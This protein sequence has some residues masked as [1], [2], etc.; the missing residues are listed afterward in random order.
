MQTKQLAI[1]GRSGRSGERRLGA[2]RVTTGC[3][4]CKKRR[5]KCDEAKPSCHRCTSTGRKCDGYA[6]PYV[7]LS[8]PDRSGSVRPTFQ[9]GRP[10]PLSETT[11][12]SPL[13]ASEAENRAFRYFAHGGASTLSGYMDLDLWSR[14]IPQI[15]HAETA[16]RHAVVAIGSL[17]IN[18][19]ARLSASA[20]TSGSVVGTQ[21]SFALQHY[22]K[23]IHSTLTNN[24]IGRPDILIQRITFLLFFCI[25]VLQGHDDAA[26]VLFER[27]RQAEFLSFN[28]YETSSHSASLMTTF[29]RMSL[30]YGMINGTLI[31][32]VGFGSSETWNVVS[33]QIDS[34]TDARAELD[35]LIL[36]SQDLV[37]G[38]LKFPWL[39]AFQAEGDDVAQTW[40]EDSLGDL[41]CSVMAVKNALDSWYTRFTAFTQTQVPFSDR[42]SISACML[43]LHYRMT[44]IWLLAS[45]EVSEM[46][47]DDHLAD[48]EDA[49]SMARSAL[50]LMKRQGSTMSFSFEMCLIPPLYM[51][52][53]SCRYP[54]LRRQA[55]A[56]LRQAPAQEGMWNRDLLARVAERVIEIEEGNGSFSDFDPE[57]GLVVLPP[58]EARVKVAAVSLRTTLDD[59]RHGRVVNFFTMPQGLKESPTI[60]R[61]FFAL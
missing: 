59:G 23:A 47:Y 9:R 24:N 50:D 57:H 20:S 48:F 43:F 32:T 21:L 6:S 58:E 3:I 18:A 33:E 12:N 14:F 49:L 41:F 34:I 13:T 46:V 4:T 15:C 28:H 5:I 30:Q 1:P 8:Q 19:D 2:R 55:L 35:V 53:I 44:K 11:L 29:V 42:D 26:W 39:A 27:A 61:N 16:V 25:E 17:L 52:V 56:L 31:P 38:G 22:N 51:M 45:T 54:I 10:S 37:T 60:Q 40:S 7:F 36:R